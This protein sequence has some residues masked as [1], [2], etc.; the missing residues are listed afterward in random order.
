MQYQQQKEKE[1]GRGMP[2]LYS[3]PLARFSRLQKGGQT[4]SNMIYLLTK[5]T[6]TT[7]SKHA[8]NQIHYFKQPFII[9]QFKEITQL[10]P[11]T[12]K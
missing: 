4:K 6:S 7:C 2:G 10:W 3:T 11:S 8:C 12:Y 5:E 1:G 9:N